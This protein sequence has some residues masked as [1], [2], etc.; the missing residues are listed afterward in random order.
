[1]G[2]ESVSPISCLSSGGVCPCGVLQAYRWPP[3]ESAMAACSGVG[4]LL[5]LQFALVQCS[6]RTS[7]QD[8]HLLS[9]KV[10]EAIIDGPFQ[11]RVTR[12]NKISHVLFLLSLFCLLQ[13]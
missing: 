4:L 12:N 11:M 10:G 13:E 1:M 8:L 7:Y 3:W 9:G 5:P 2:E 6:G